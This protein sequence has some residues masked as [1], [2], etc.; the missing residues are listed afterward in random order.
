MDG[1]KV[2]VD[3]FVGAVNEN[4]KSRYRLMQIPHV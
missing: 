4:D 2:S 1:K 3:D